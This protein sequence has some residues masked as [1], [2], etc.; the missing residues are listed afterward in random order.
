MKK[1]NDV[2]RLVDHLTWTYNADMEYLIGEGNSESPLNKLDK[3]IDGFRH[4]VKECGSPIEHFAQSMV[5]NANLVLSWTK[6]LNRQR[7]LLIDQGLTDER[8]FAT[9]RMRL[10][11]AK[12]NK[13]PKEDNQ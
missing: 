8:G 4:Y 12:K 11:E 7:Q 9:V 1:F 10:D 2:D 6:Q 13:K 5:D 3:S